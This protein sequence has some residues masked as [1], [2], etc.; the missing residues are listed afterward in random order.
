MAQT[1]PQGASYAD[2]ERTAGYS[3][4]ICI[5]LRP[6]TEP[7]ADRTLPGHTNAGD[8]ERYRPAVSYRQDGLPWRTALCLVQ[9]LKSECKISDT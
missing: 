1:H 5:A 3:S 8:N 2:W 4:S 7:C 9:R 6:E